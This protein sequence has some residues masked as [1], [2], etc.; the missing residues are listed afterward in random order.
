M[1]CPGRC[2][3]QWIEH[4]EPKGHQF[5]SRPGHK[6][7]LWARPPVEGHT[8]GNHTSTFLSLSFSLPSP[9]KKKMPVSSNSASKMVS[10]TTA[11][12][13]H[14]KQPVHWGKRRK[15]L[16]V[17]S[18]SSLLS[19]PAGRRGGSRAMDVWK[20]IADM[21]SGDDHGVLPLSRK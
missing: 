15:D 8:R 18:H 4:Y 12:E 9:L 10:V 3:A 21:D 17:L 5:D 7:G 16:E 14:Y 20:V 1:S 11:K 6:P 2:V 19:V 13:A